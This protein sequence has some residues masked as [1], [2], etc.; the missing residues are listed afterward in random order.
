MGTGSV[1]GNWVGSAGCKVSKGKDVEFGS[2]N[3]ND[4]DD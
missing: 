1:L 3:C 4:T 2:L